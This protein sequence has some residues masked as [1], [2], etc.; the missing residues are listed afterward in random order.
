MFRHCSKKINM[1]TTRKSPQ[2]RSKNPATALS[3]L[4]HQTALNQGVMPAVQGEYYSYP[5]LFTKEQPLFALMKCKSNKV[6]KISEISTLGVE[7][8]AFF[9]CYE[10]NPQILS[11]KEANALGLLGSTKI[12]DV[13]DDIRFAPTDLT[14]EQFLELRDSKETTV[15]V[16]A[17]EKV[18]HELRN[19]VD[20]HEGLVVAFKTSGGKYGMFL[21]EEITFSSIQIEACHIL[22]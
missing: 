5:S 15:L 7:I 8:N 12:K 17:C 14:D 20:L 4:Q 13:F 6:R 9:Q 1:K 11:I 19:V 3:V 22:L 10:E 21:V 16:S 2:G 18:S